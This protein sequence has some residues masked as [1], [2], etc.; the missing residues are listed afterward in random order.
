MKVATLSMPYNE[1]RRKAEAYKRAM[2]R[3]PQAADE[4]L[5]K[6]YSAIARGKR[7]IDI[8]AVIHAGGYDTEHR[9]KLAIARADQKEIHFFYDG[10]RPTFSSWSN[11]SKKNPSRERHFV[12]P[13][14]PDETSPR[15]AVLRDVH[16]RAMVPLVPADV[17]PDS[18]LRNF[19]ILWEAN[20]VAAPVDPILLRRIGGSFFAIIAQWDL[21]ELER[22]VMNGRIGS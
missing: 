22:A 4:V 11:G 16:A 1:A 17:R 5:M 8:N 20:W 6:G 2:Q 15:W 7:V 12:L 21:T 9:P 14:R 10:A 18:H 19:H 13:P 3:N